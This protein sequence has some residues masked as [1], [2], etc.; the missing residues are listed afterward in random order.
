MN[1][2][3]QLMLLAEDM[4]KRDYKLAHR[5]QEVA[6]GMTDWVS[7]DDGDLVPNTYYLVQCDGGEWVP[8]LLNVYSQWV[9]NSNFLPVEVFNGL[10]KVL[11]PTPPKES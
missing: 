6:R 8:F 7:V 10:N 11:M 3:N 2:F 1:T 4:K 5:C 9:C